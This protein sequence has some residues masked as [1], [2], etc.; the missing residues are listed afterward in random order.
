MNNNLSVLMYHAI[1]DDTSAS[2][3]VD[4]HY[5]VTRAKFREHLELVR[6]MGFSASSVASI[7]A[8]KENYGRNETVCQIAFTFD[9]GHESNAAAAADLLA[10]S[11]SADLFINSSMV[12]KKNYLDWHALCDLAKAGI[13]IQS[14]SDTH[15]YLDELSEDEIK[16]ELATSKS[17]IEDHVGVAVT[18][19]AP[20][21]G[22]MKKCVTGI[23]QELGYQGICSSRVG[24][25]NKGATPWNI[26]RL[27]VL[28]TTSDI[29]LSRWINQEKSEIFRLKLRHG[30]LTSAKFLIG[31]QGYERL[32]EQLLGRATVGNNNGT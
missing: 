11:G 32:R 6:E 22:R 13:S 23:A 27:A 14:H 4:F 5:A 7:L 9:D 8:S 20:P 19:F 24:L 18:L 16:N 28:S 21:G 12:G 15:C 25:W 31:N 1:T 3:D 2:L 10:I 29:Q 17:K 30:L 26:P